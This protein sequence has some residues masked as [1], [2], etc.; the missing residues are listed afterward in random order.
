RYGLDIEVPGASILSAFGF[1]V[2][3]LW[4]DVIGLA[5]MSAVVIVVAYGAMHVLLVEKR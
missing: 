5:V 3:A 1:Q 2:L 4:N